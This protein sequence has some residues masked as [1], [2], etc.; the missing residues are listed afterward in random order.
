MQKS[1]RFIE[2]C[3]LSLLKEGETHGYRLMEKLIQREFVEE[4]INISII[5]RALRSMEKDLLVA[6]TWEESDLGPN[7]RLYN[8]TNKG[9]EELDKWILL[10]KKKRKQIDLIIKMYEQY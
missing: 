6:S 3:L 9:I 7:K 4:N 10:I 1:G 2:A 5:Y 8:I